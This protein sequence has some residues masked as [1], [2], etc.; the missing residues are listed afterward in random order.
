[1]AEFFNIIEGEDWGSFDRLTDRVY[2]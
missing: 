1:L 2:S